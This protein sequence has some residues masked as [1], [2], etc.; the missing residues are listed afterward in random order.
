V[1]GSSFRRLIQTKESL[2]FTSVVLSTGVTDSVCTMEV[3]YLFVGLLCSSGHLDIYWQYLL[4]A[5]K[6]FD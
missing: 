6:Q 1:T 2:D 3:A 5:L 4:R